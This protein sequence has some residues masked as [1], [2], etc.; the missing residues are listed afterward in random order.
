M[1]RLLFYI[2]LKFIFL[3]LIA[4]PAIVQSKEASYA[5]INT[6]EKKSPKHEYKLYSE[7]GVE[8]LDNVFSLSDSQITTMRENDVRD[9]DSGRYRDM[10]SI[11][12]YIL[13]PYLGIVFSIDHP[14]GGKLKIIPWFKYNYYIRNEKSRFPEAGIELTQS[15]ASDGNLSLEGKLLKG[16][17]KKNYILDYNDINGNNN[18]TK[19][20][21]IYAGAFY[22][23]YEGLITYDHRVVKKKNNKLGIGLNVKPFVGYEARKY[24]AEFGNRDRKISLGGIGFDFDSKSNVLL[25]VTYKYERV[26]YPDGNELALVNE[27][28]LGFDI[29]GDGELDRNA[30]LFTNVDRS[31]TR[32]TLELVPAIKLRKKWLLSAGYRLRKTLYK[33]NNQLDLEHYGQSLYKREFKAGIEYDFLKSWSVQFEYTKVDDEGDEFDDDS[34]I[35]N[36]YV[37]AVRH[38]FK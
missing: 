21:R 16:F 28:I 19:D 20:E 11:S 27:E 35:L 24:N 3:I 34:Y 17:F 8:Y 30:A 9:Q 10:E 23:E 12:D 36:R 33:S 29:N 1:K 13:T 6:E 37:F 25:N 26:D 15:I 5:N 22:D 14:S 31:S 18:I 32:H 7:I 2:I 4:I 38:T